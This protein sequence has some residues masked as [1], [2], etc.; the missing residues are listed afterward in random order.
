ML[1]VFCLLIVIRSEENSLAAIMISI[2]TISK[3]NWNLVL[4]RVTV[5]F[6]WKIRFVYIAPAKRLKNQVSQETRKTSKNNHN[7]SKAL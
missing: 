1:I 5:W 7:S 6:S 2:L 3:D 4:T